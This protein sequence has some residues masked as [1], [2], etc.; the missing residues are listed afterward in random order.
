M[1][2]R[3]PQLT[4]RSRNDAV[5]KSSSL[6]RVALVT[7]AGQ[8]VGRGIALELA[9]AGTPVAVNDRYEDRA[10]SV[11]DEIIALG[12]RA[13]AAAFDIRNAEEV[14]QAANTVR[15]TLGPI[16]IL[17]NNVGGGVEVGGTLG[18]KFKDSDPQAWRKSIDLDLLGSLT[19]IHVLLPDM[20]AAGWGR[21]I[22]ISSGA[23]SRGHPMGLTIYGAAK[24]GIEGAMRHLAL[25][26]AAAGVTVNS[27]ALG[28][29]ANNAE[30][31]QVVGAGAAG[32]GTLAGVPIG[33][34]IEPREVGA[35]VAWLSSDAAGG[36]TGQTIHINGGTFHGR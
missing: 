26:E 7:G 13:V 30:R 34:L 3:A 21:I 28:L 19:V 9:A 33:R 14:R 31:P 1:F 2:P 11:R 8:G 29:M 27:V 36:V 16:A 12:G 32:V 23:G 22:Q 18:V 5:T 20:V 25:E 15:E 4:V 6:S 24:A 10:A 35:C 17:V